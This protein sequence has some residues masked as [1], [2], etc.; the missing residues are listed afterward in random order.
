[1]SDCS[2]SDADGSNKSV[3]IIENQ[4]F[5]QVI[6]TTKVS[7]KMQSDEI[8]KLVKSFFLIQIIK[9]IF[10]LDSLIN[11]SHSTILEM[12]SRKSLAIFNFA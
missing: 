5:A 4:C 3:K 12:E 1:M 11:P 8:F 6:D 10:F 9:Y 7:A 2:V